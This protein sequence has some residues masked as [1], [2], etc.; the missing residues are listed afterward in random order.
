MM[1]FE[2]WVP[3]F[4]KNEVSNKD[5][6]SLASKLNVNLSNIHYEHFSTR[7]RT[8]LRELLRHI[9]QIIDQ[10]DDAK[11]ANYQKILEETE[12]WL[13]TT[14][15]V[16]YQCTYA[17]CSFKGN[18]HSKYVRHLENSHFTDTDI[19]CNYRK[20]CR[21]RFKNLGELK[22]H[23]EASHRGPAGDQEEDADTADRSGPSFNMSSDPTRCIMMSCHMRPTNIPKYPEAFDSH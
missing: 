22:S 11:R 17:G 6:T 9:L 3:K 2:T 8:V 12:A 18:R 7:K 5:I 23:I 1:D 19:L 20:Q 21:R 4:L 13:N 15:V 16:G 14:K 10:N